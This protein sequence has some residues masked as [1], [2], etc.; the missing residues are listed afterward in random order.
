[1]FGK[2][3]QFET[4]KSLNDCTCGAHKN[5]ELR[6]SKLKN[7][8]ENSYFVLTIT[9]FRD[10]MHSIDGKT[11][12]GSDTM[13]DE[14][15]TL[16]EEALLFAK[17]KIEDA[18][19]ALSEFLPD[20]SEELNWFLEEMKNQLQALRTERLMQMNSTLYAKEEVL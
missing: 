17:E 16:K 10:T 11:M 14:L 8:N 1:M 6:N 3:C 9:K 19:E 7:T 13:N 20:L 15:L 12:K 2:G 5:S 4:E 18:A